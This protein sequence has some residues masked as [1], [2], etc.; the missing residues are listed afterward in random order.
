MIRECVFGSWELLLTRLQNYSAAIKKCEWLTKSWDISCSTFDVVFNLLYVEA[1]FVEAHDFHIRWCS[2]QL[3]VTRR[4]GVTSRTGTAKL[5][6]HMIS[7]PVFS[8]IRVAQSLVV[9]LMFCT[10]TFGH[11]VVCSSSINGLWL[12]LYYLQTLLAYD[13]IN[14]FQFSSHR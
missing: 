2:C 4:P 7:P 8:G 1:Q 13:N 11:C 6:E 12:P 10:F 3:T 9:W 14:T 5:S